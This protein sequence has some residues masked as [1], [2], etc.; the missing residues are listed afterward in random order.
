[1]EVCHWE[2]ITLSPGRAAGLVST[3]L[4]NLFLNLEVDYQA[5]PR[6]ES[7]ENLRSKP[8]ERAEEGGI[9]TLHDNGSG[10]DEGESNSLWV[11]AEAL[12]DGHV[13]FSVG[14]ISGVVILVGEIWVDNAHLADI[15]V[16][17]TEDI[18]S[19]GLNRDD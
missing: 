1:M 17:D 3:S 11:E 5:I 16:I 6:Y 8:V 10:E 15:G 18:I 19:S 14:S 12:L 7:T 9:I 4:P 2:L 13:M